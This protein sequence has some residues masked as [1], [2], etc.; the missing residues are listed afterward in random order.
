MRTRRYKAPPEAEVAYYHCMSRAVNRE[1]LFKAEDHEK[2]LEVFRSQAAFSG[3]RILTFCLLSNHFHILLEVPK[4]P[5]NRLSEEALFQ[6]LGAV[7]S[8]NRVT[9]L[10]RQWTKL[11]EKKRPKWEEPYLMRMWDLSQFMKESKQ[12]FTQWYNRKRGMDGS[13]WR[14][15]FTS[16]LVGLDGRA[17]ATMAAYIDLNPV[18]AG[19]VKDPKDYRWS[20]YG[21]A[22]GGNR[23]AREAFGRVM[24]MAEGHG[25]GDAFEAYRM[26]L[27]QSGVQQGVEGPAGTEPV[28]KGISPERVK[29]VVANRGK[30]TLGEFL[31]CRVRHMSEGAIFGTKGF[32]D[33]MLGRHREVFGSRRKTGARRLRFLESGEYYTLKDI[34]RTPWEIGTEATSPPATTG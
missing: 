16:V 18:R 32:V 10:R 17:L 8:P 26:W 29:E 13:R 4:R 5:E 7:Y 1:W 21:Q 30:L 19:I 11:P 20:G 28:R 31:M 34:R 23:E 6:R 12:R 33:R 27:Y 15:R 24:E 25:R 3:I 14:S 9:E 22:M 2:F